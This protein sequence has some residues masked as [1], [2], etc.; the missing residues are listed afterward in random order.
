MFQCGVCKSG[1]DRSDH[2]IRHIRSHTK[3]RP[4]VCSVCTKGFARQDLLKRHLGTHNR[5]E[6]T[7]S[8]RE[9]PVINQSGRPS[10]R[11]QQACRSCA[12]K[13]LKCSELKPCGRCIEKNVR[14]EFEAEEEVSGE[15]ETI[16]HITELLPSQPGDNSFDQLGQPTEQVVRSGLEFQNGP[17]E[18]NAAPSLKANMQADQ[19]YTSEDDFMTG[20]LYG[21]LNI[22][23]IGE[24]L[25]QDSEST[26]G[27]LDFS[28]LNEMNSFNSNPQV[29][30]PS[31][32]PS[33]SSSPQPKTVGFGR[34]AFRKSSVHTSW[35]P[36]LD[37][38]RRLEYPNL[39]LQKKLI[40]QDIRCSFDSSLLRSKSISLLTRD[41]ILAMILRSSC[42]SATERI[43]RSFPSL[44]VL[45]GLI[46]VAFYHMSENQVIP[47]IHV[48]SIDLDNQRPEFL[49]AVIAYASVY[50]PSQPVQKFGYALQ[51]IVRGSILIL[52]E[53]KHSTLRESG[54]C[55]AFY[56]QLDLALYSCVSRK[57]EMAE[58]YSMLGTTMLRH[59]KLLSEEAYS[60]PGKILAMPDLTIQQKWLM[61]AEQET[62]KR[63]GYFA[64]TLDAH[65]SIV[66][67][68]KTLFSY[69]ELRAPL[70]SCKQLWEAET[71]TSWLNILQ[72]DVQM[73]I[74]QPLS[75]YKILRQPQLIAP[76][77]FNIDMKSA[78]IIYLAGLWSLISEYQQMICIIPS[79]QQNNDFVMNSRHAD[80]TSNLELFKIESANLGADFPEVLIQ[81]ELMSLH[82]NAPLYSLSYFVGMGSEVKAQKASPTAHQWF[83]SPKSRVALWHC[84]QIFRAAWLFK[85]KKLAEIHVLALYQATLV[86][87]VWA[88][89]RKAQG[90]LTAS[91]KERVMLDGEETLM[92]TKFLK[93]YPA[94]PGLTSESGSFLSL[95]NPVIAPDIANAIIQKNWNSQQMPRTAEE[96]SRMLQSFSS[97]CREKFDIP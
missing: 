92:T 43:L 25:Q 38:N 4:F 89:L 62:Q 18:S 1:Y 80:L 84:G 21:T 59:G 68:T 52:V 48:P 20:I 12:A 3:Q 35:E 41:R 97:I 39:I 93:S 63:L 53:E 77:K 10:Q 75:L 23:D 22:P 56:I 54:V 94:E 32:S 26:L 81:Q 76:Q 7:T 42:S 87:W 72:Q 95:D 37:D 15:D 79:T 5:D 78:S 45:N 13:K 11:V 17:L 70:P 36:S 91:S 86:L 67:K 60:S 27:D 49:G 55:Q 51:E 74:E 31:L 96:A 24:F 2:L 44:E 40:P 19:L 50:S 6:S 88:L 33:S 46:Q 64:M 65:N 8:D 90:N 83:E 73:P 66:R 85:P 34:E 58:G 29:S 9:T 82:L 28:F 71:A 30:L 14:C 16:Q 61:W 47:F 57:M 69:A